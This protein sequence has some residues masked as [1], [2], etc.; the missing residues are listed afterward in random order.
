MDVLRTPDSCFEALKDFPFEPHYVQL[1]NGAD[2]ALRLHYIDEGPQTAAPILLLHGEPSWSY[3]YRKMIAILVAQGHRVIAPDLIGFGRSDKPS[4]TSDY[5]YERHVG[6][7]KSFLRELD[8]R[9]ITLVCQDWGGLIGLRI[10]ADLPE[11]FARVVAAN[12]GLPTGEETP[13]EAFKQWQKYSQLS[14]DFEI[15]KIVSQGCVNRLKPN[16]IDAYNA[17]FPSDAYKA[18]ARIFPS[19]VPTSPESPGASE[20]KKAWRVLRSWNKP[21]LTA[22]SDSDP[23]TAGA[24]KIMQKLIPGCCEQSHVT[25]QGGGHFLQEDCGEALANV[26]DRFVT[27]TR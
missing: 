19:L 7:I 22:F 18:G 25:I 26:V 8:L 17:P 20:N 9:N 27:E 15:G 1:A 21:F 4:Q 5:S 24:D 10:V 14:P 11:I 12:T 23:I 13:N 3:L 2:V 16:Q 6:W